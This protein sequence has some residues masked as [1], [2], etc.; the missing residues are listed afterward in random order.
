MPASTGCRVFAFRVASRCGWT[1]ERVAIS[2]IVASAR[3][4]SHVTFA[5]NSRRSSFQ[6]TSTSPVRSARTQSVESRA[7]VAYAGR[8]VVVDVAGVDAGVG[9]RIPRPR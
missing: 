2:V 7:V 4:A 3:D 8:E 5:F 6:T 1:P 9:A